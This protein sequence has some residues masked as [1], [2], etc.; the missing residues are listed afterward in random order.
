MSQVEMEE[1]QVL[2]PQ[3]SDSIEPYWQERRLKMAEATERQCNVDDL[4]CQMGVLSHLRGMQEILGDER[5]KTEFPEFE[6]LDNAVSEKIKAQETSLRDALERCGL[7]T[8]AETEE[9][10]EEE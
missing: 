5:F 1:E 8:M 7:P 10:K 6:R 9:A 2:P 3:F 4:M